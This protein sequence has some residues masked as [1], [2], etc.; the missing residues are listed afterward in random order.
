V[1]GVAVAG[2]IAGA[3]GGVADGVLGVVE[4]ELAG[5]AGAPLP[6][7]AALVAVL[8]G[9]AEALVA[10]DV[11][12]AADAPGCDGDAGLV[13]VIGGALGFELPPQPIAIARHRLDAV[14]V[15]LLDMS[16]LEVSLG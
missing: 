16:H 13:D 2:C 1:L 12:G 7:A 15:D 8:L 10:G 3:A 14:N 6:A 5:L 9:V 11:G 4:G